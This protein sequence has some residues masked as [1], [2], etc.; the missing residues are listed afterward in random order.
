MQVEVS[1]PSSVW[2]FSIRLLRASITSTALWS[3]P[4]GLSAPREPVQI[5]NKGT[6]VLLVRLT[7][8][9]PVDNDSTPHADAMRQCGSRLVLVNPSGGFAARVQTFYSER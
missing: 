2:P 1:N 9:P 3:T 5:E 4:Q 8:V 7:V 6:E